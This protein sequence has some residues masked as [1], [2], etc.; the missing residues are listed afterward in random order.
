MVERYRLIAEYLK[1]IGILTES[2]IKEVL[3]AQMETGGRLSDILTEIGFS[4]TEQ[5]KDLI[6]SQSGLAP[7]PTFDLEVPLAV[8]EKISPEIAYRHRLL[9]VK[10]EGGTLTVVTDDPI[11]LLAQ[12]N[13]ESM[14]KL[15]LEFVLT[16]EAHLNI[17]LEKH[18]GRSEDFLRAAK[19]EDEIAVAFKGLAAE[20]IEEEEAPIIKLVTQMISEAVKVRASDIHIEPLEDKFRIRYR[21]DGVLHEIPGP[22]KQLQATVTSR[23]KIMAGL[24]IAEKRLPQDGRIRIEAMNK[25]L[26][27]RV[28][29]LPSLYG[30][31][32][33]MR[34][35]DKSS[36]MLG[37]Q[38]LGFS[39][40]DE[41]KFEK[42]VRLPHGMILVTGP[43][44]SGKT[45]TLYASLSYI[46][47]PNKKLITVE[48]PVEYQLSGI[49]QVQVKPSIGLTFASGL[50]T[51]LR[52]A[53]DVIMVG[54]I[55]DFETASIAIQAALTG[56]LMFSTL[57]TNDAAGAITRL[58]DMGVKPYLVSSTVKA[59]MAQR[60]VRRVCD[61]CKEPYTPTREELFAVDL[62]P[63]NL[64]GKTLYRGRGCKECAHTGF[65]GRTGIFE[66][67][68]VDDEICELIVKKASSAAIREAARKTG[69]RTLRDDGVLKILAGITTIPEVVRITHGYEE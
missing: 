63:E 68:M 9:P 37:L 59:I 7:V 43:T 44:G 57:H 17:A 41:G 8:L 25:D 38:E 12:E 49:N 5:L 36:F 50:R 60:L 45:T 1:S 33:V 32:V 2:Q 52:Q 3:N 48:D 20:A 23:V 4:K 30:E 21:I 54:E 58:I 47:K 31:S 6:S 62:K 27:I 51:M 11:N 28:S 10:F 16:Y 40:E 67:L 35:L 26:D 24:N 61:N 46:N 34:L 65:K 13:L 69:M 42:L 66:L 56:H 14:A 19:K 55:R 53:P 64:R 15:K 18:Y 39:R 22:P 29:T